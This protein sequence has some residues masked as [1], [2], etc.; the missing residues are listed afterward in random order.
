[1]I[2]PVIRFYLKTPSIRYPL[3]LSNGKTIN[4]PDPP[5]LRKYSI[6]IDM[7]Y[8]DPSYSVGKLCQME[9]NKKKN[10]YDIK[11]FDHPIMLEDEDS[12]HKKYWIKVQWKI[13]KE[14]KNIHYNVTSYF[15]EPKKYIE[16]IDKNYLLCR[17]QFSSFLLF[18]ILKFKIYFLRKRKRR[19]L[20]KKFCNEIV[21]IIFNSIPSTPIYLQ[22]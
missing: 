19:F 7:Q 2:D 3:Q 13:D 1:M 14:I 9:F 18:C 20:K 16:K 11:V 17:P 22:L 8:N 15:H 5:V 10:M 6:G 4:V 21:N 12:K